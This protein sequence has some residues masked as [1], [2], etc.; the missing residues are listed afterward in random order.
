MDYSCEEIAAVVECSVNTVGSVSDSTGAALSA[1]GLW[2]IAFGNDAHNQPHNTLFFSAGS[3]S[4]TTGILGRIDLGA[5][6][7]RL[8]EPPV[9]ALTAT[10]TDPLGI[11]IVQF[12]VNG[13][14]LGAHTTM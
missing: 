2:G 5:I 8:G 11:S 13:S 14:T 4:G 1:P 7:P 12:F 3:N 6:A 9:V 10:A